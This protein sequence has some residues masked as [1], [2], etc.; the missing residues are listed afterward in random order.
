MDLVWNKQ[1]NRLL[2]CI[3]C[4]RTVSDLDAWL[5][6][7]TATKYAYD[8]TTITKE[9][10]IKELLPKLEEEAKRVLK[11][12]VS[13]GLIANPVKTSFLIVNPELKLEV[14]VEIKVGNNTVTQE[15]TAK[16]LRM[17]FDDNSNWKAP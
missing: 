7:S 16:L 8:S 15:K 12:M 17:M 2:I 3:T 10:S 6:D 13:N 4:E 11:F 1:T 5:Q 9:K 14:P